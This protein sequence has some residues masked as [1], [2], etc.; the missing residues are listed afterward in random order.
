MR[1]KDFAIKMFF[2]AFCALLGVS[3]YFYKHFPL[4]FRQWNPFRTIN[5]MSAPCSLYT[6]MDIYKQYMYTCISNQY[7]PLFL[8]YNWDYVYSLISKSDFYHYF[9]KDLTHFGL[10]NTT[11]GL[12]FYL[13]IS[14]AQQRIL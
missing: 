1:H 14:T 4:F 2:V 12:L 7:L 8:I 10:F 3:I 11:N 6:D 5:Y 9:P 13:I